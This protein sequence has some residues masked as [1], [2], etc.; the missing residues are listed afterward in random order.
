MGPAAG[1]ATSGGIG[2]T[3]ISKIWKSRSRRIDLPFQPAEMLLDQKRLA[4]YYTYHT[5]EHRGRLNQ[6]MTEEAQESKRSSW[7]FPR[8]YVWLCR[9]MIPGY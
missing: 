5:M 2:L 7:F 3:R 9:W 4:A 6:S 1:G 8:S